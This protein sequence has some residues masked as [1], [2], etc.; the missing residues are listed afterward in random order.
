MVSCELSGPGPGP[1]KLCR[2]CI[3]MLSELANDI[4]AFYETKIK[5]QPDGRGGGGLAFSSPPHSP[6]L[7]LKPP[8]FHQPNFNLTTFKLMSICNHSTTP[9]RFARGKLNRVRGL[10]H[11]EAMW[12]GGVKML[13]EMNE[14]DEQAGRSRLTLGFCT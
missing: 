11:G 9:R 5:K 13:M 4:I 6:L 7:N 3:S 1:E 12:D 2:D 14:I 8:L 10:V